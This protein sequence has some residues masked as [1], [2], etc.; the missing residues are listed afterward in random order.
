M[1]TIDRLTSMMKE[2]KEDISQLKLSNANPEHAFQQ[3][4]E[5][6]KQPDQQQQQQKQQGGKTNY[7]GSNVN[8]NLDHTTEADR[9]SSIGHIQASR[10]MMKSTD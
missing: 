6:Q 4:Q 5:Q 3:Q 7:R 1:L 9:T 10:P 2:V 8:P